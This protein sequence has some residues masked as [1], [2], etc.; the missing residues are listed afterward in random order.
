M[1]RTFRLL[2]AGLLMALAAVS[3]SA[4]EIYSVFYDNRFGVID[5]STGAFTQI[6]TL[7]IAQAAGIADDNGTLFAQSLQSELIE[8]DPVSGASSVIGSAGLQLSSVGF[9]GGLNGIF[10]VD[11]A[12]NLYSINPETGAATL[13]GATGLAANNGSWDTSLSDNGTNLYFTAG[14]AGAIDQ[15]YEINTA[16]GVA[17]D[18]GSTGVSGI[19][20]SAIV[21][22]DLELFQYH[23]SGSTDYIYSAPLGSTD[24][25]AG[26]VLG[27]QVVDGGITLGT[28]LVKSSEDFAAPEP[29][30]SLL[31]GSGLIGLALWRR[32]R[33]APNS[34]K[35]R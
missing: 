23:W 9:A 34:K 19:A 1:A 17:T 11:Y 18:L 35:S 30:S 6:S 5:D 14:G 12:S 8:I 32:R 22:G 26:P 33:H 29:C 2:I 24:F 3:A 13:V 31:F 21:N 4:A 15:L 20:G 25:T 7:P 16:T 28:S 10:E 27:T